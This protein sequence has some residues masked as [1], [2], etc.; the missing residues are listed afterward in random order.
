M[1]DYFDIQNNHLDKF[2]KK[3]VEQLPREIEKQIKYLNRHQPSFTAEELKD[4]TE[5]LEKIL[6]KTNEYIEELSK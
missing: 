5:R 2:D 4:K 1:I 6:E 3:K